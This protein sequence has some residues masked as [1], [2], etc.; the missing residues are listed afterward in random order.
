MYSLLFI[1]FIFNLRFFVSDDNFLLKAFFSSLIFLSMYSMVKM[2]FLHVSFVQHVLPSFKLSKDNDFRPQQSWAL[3]STMSRILLIFHLLLIQYLMNI[4]LVRISS[5]FKHYFPQFYLPVCKRASTT[6]IVQSTIQNTSMYH[7]P[8]D[9]FQTAIP[10]HNRV[11]A[12]SSSFAC[13]SPPTGPSVSGR[14]KPL[15]CLQGY[16]TGS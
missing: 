8:N 15:F 12:L 14:E 11:S 9:F 6:S 4:L 2:K 10:C 16:K 5:C 3:L 13:T 1:C 7:L